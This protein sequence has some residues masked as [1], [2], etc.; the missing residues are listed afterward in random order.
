MLLGCGMKGVRSF[1]ECTFMPVV[2]AAE[3]RAA[4]FFLAPPFLGLWRFV[5]IVFPL[6][7]PL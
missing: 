6:D 3:T 7:K 4:K 2:I 5:S 1:N